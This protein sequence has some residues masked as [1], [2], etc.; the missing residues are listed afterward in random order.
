MINGVYHPYKDVVVITHF[1]HI[2]LMSL[3]HGTN[4]TTISVFL[5]LTSELISLNNVLAK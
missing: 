2:C 4:Y 1:Y 3:C 5:K